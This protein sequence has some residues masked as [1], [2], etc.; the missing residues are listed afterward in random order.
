MIKQEKIVEVRD[1]ASIVEIIS[2]YVTLKKTGR[3]YMGL[4]PFHA[5]K[6]PSFTVSADKGIF[7]CFGCQAGGS[8]FQFLMQYEHLTFPEAVERI[9]KRYGLSIG[10][11]DRL[12]GA[13]EAGERERLY[14]IN[15][16]AAVNY[17]EMLWRHAEGKQA[18]RY[19]RSR[20]LDDATIRH[21]M[22]GYAP[23]S[24]SGLVDLLAKEKLSVKDAMRLGLIGQRNARQFHEKFFS[25]V[26]FP[27]INAAGKTVGF[28]ARVLNQSL[29]KYLNSSE[30]PLFHKGSTLYGLFHARDGIRTSDRV[31]VVEGY[32]DVIALSQCGLSCAVA[33]LGTALT[34]N[35]VRAL[36]RYTQ[37]VIALFDGDEAGRKAAARSFEVFIEAGLL[38]RAA[39]L[40]AGE[41]PDT[42]VRRHG[43]PAV[44]EVLA[45]AVPLADYYFSWLE[46]RHGSSLQG[47]SQTAAEI[48]RVLAKVTNA[49]E[50][51]LL[52]RR[53]VDTLGIREELLRRP[54][55]RG[56]TSKAAPSPAPP[57]ELADRS[58][59]AERALLAVMLRFPS[60]M[61]AA[62]NE[63][64]LRQWLAP[65][66]RP[67]VDVILAEWQEREE[68]DLFRVSQKA[69]PE[70]SG[71]ISALALEGERVSDS[72]VHKVAADCLAYLRRKHLRGLE[73]NLRMAIRAAEESKDEKAK[74]ERI[75][76]WQEV[77]RKERQLD[78]RLEPKTTIR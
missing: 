67:L 47:K 73:R 56:Q 21:F 9:A 20:G 19:L 53:A 11:G 46:Q 76:E 5:E 34:V 68:I 41:D 66:W 44:E 64:E 45:R 65:Q 6:T 23:Q 43:K 58:D 14:R 42:F 52:I 7:H 55:A 78:R 24:G 12:A 1:R 37:N 40:P 17:Q 72:D 31:V 16:R 10:P 15:E 57:Q 33:T 30:T 32:L 35:H 3:N 74:R 50:I 26:M 51:D 49:F 2:D 62:C 22:L 70:L 54:A 60:V 59:R 29:P 36:V 69:P 13:N 39:F 27:I 18:L 8:V 75:L 25:R 63:S 4:C 48:S 28:G 61:R 77:V 71:E 38:G